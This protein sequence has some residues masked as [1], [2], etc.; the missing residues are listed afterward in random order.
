[1]DASCANIVV[2]N[3][4]SSHAEIASATVSADLFPIIERPVYV[5]VLAVYDSS[6]TVPGSK[7][8]SG[9]HVVTEFGIDPDNGCLCKIEAEE[10]TLDKFLL[11][12]RLRVTLFPDDGPEMHCLTLTGENILRAIE[13]LMPNSNTADTTPAASPTL[14]TQL[15]R[16]TLISTPAFEFVIGRATRVQLSLSVSYEQL[17][18]LVEELL[19]RKML[20]GS[21]CWGLLSVD[22]ILFQTLLRMFSWSLPPVIPFVFHAPKSSLTLE[23]RGLNLPEDRTVLT[24]TVLPKT[25]SVI[26]PV[27]MQLC[28]AMGKR[29]FPI[30]VLCGSLCVYTFSTRTTLGARITSKVKTLFNSIYKSIFI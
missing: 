17:R 16:D 23:G 3:D 22:G 14:Q 11:T 20:R 27:A 5:R 2:I 29:L 28:W 15:Q 12:E 18:L 4:P 25:Q 7:R 9:I 1:M 26:R 10:V 30:F 13:L 8:S 24:E 19:S 21:Y 6:Q